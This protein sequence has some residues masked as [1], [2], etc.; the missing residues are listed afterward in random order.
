VETELVSVL[1]L[2]VH[3]L[4]GRGL[5]QI[6]SGEPRLAVRSVQLECLASVDEALATDPRIVIFEEGGRMGLDELLERSR[7]SVVV[8][9]SL[10][11]GEIWTLRRD[12]LNGK[13]DGVIQAI[14]ATCLGIPTPAVSR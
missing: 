2:Y 6:L 5:E 12:R 11:T 1:V 10:G 3:P 13:G 14:L 9:V 8:D 4:L 7:C